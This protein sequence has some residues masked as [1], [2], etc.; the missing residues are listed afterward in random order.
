VPDVPPPGSTIAW[1]IENKLFVAWLEKTCRALGV[2]FT[3][4]ELTSATKNEQG[5]ISSLVLSTGEI[6]TAD[7]YIDCSGFSSEL[8][9]KVHQ[10]P[11]TDFSKSLF[12]D[13]AVAGGWDRDGEEVLPYTASD[14]MQAGWCWRIDHPER[15]HRGYVYSSD[16]LSEEQAIDEYSTVAP[17]AKN[18]RI[19]KFRSGAYERSWIGNTI[20]I[21]NAAG[22]VE[23]LEAT[24]LMVICLQSRWLADGLIDSEQ[25]P[26]SS[27][28][29]LYNT[30]NDRLWQTIRDFLGMHYRFNNRIGNEFWRRCQHEIPLDAVEDIVAFYQENGPSA[31]AS[32]LLGTNDPFGLDGYLAIL[33][34][35]RVPHSRPYRIPEKEQTLWNRS[36][37]ERAR[38]ASQALTMPEVI[39]HLNNPQTWKQVRRG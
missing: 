12:C 25:Q 28:I 3:D 6:K 9:G 16:H 14:T 29:R 22:F 2:V 35:L 13:R 33:C 39:S 4:A 31:I 37:R 7:L 27:L 11:F 8:L 23:P 18:P 32:G 21:G 10:E 26:S 20:A 19:V 30:M 24:A 5:D 36:L 17:K 15:I 34:G 38:I 1:H